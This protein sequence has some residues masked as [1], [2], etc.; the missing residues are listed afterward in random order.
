[1]TLKG[2]KN[3]YNV[4]FIEESDFPTT[5]NLDVLEKYRHG[6][7][8]LTSDFPYVRPILWGTIWFF[9]GMIGWIAF[10][11]LAAAGSLGGKLGD[12]PMMPYVYI[13][14]VVFFF[15][16]PAGIIGEIVRWKKNRNVQ[17]LKQ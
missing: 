10:S 7:N 13:F 2:K 12:S 17:A 15:S 5:S 16:L 4:K 14:G 8:I 6:H 9:I 3:H 1:M 11:G